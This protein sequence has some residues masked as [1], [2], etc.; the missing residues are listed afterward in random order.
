MS[1]V[2]LQLVPQQGWVE[3]PHATHEPP[4]HVVPLVVQTLLA[5]Q[6]WLRPPHAA[7]VAPAQ[8]VPPE[9]TFPQQGCPLAPQAEHVAGVPPQTAPVLQLVPQQ[10]C[11]LAPQG[12]HFDVEVEHR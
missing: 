4:E 2:V 6:I 1:V 7:H 11:P 5:Q 3:A 10:G 9:Q 8:T 12:A